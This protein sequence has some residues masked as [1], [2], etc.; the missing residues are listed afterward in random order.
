MLVSFAQDGQNKEERAPL[1]HLSS[2]I[3]PVLSVKATA[4][5]SSEDCHRLPTLLA[6][7]AGAAGSVGQGRPGV[8][9][10]PCPIDGL[11]SGSDR[12]PR[13]ESAK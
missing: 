6:R 12:R 2:F 13:L 8:V 11:G 3:G 4:R 9:L 7:R 10:R 1:F 5:Q